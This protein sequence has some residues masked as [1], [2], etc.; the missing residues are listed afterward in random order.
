MTGWRGEGAERMDVRVAKRAHMLMGKA[1]KGMTGLQTG[2]VLT[3]KDDRIDVA[4]FS[5]PSLVP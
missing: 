3:E 1:Q 4:Q 2:R 5:P